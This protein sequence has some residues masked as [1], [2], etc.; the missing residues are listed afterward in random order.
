MN[1]A[2]YAQFL[3]IGAFICAIGALLNLTKLKKR[4]NVTFVLSAAFLDLGVIFW[5][6]KAHAS[7]P[8][9]SAASALLVA[10]LVLDVIVR[11]NQRERLP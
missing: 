11:N 9:I 8:L 4:G 1:E 10:L 7:T 3:S 5:L 2:Q 6:V